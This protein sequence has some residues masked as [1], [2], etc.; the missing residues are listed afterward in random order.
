MERYNHLIPTPSLI[1]HAMTKSVELRL[2]QTQDRLKAR[3][4]TQIL[5]LKKEEERKKKLANLSREVAR[6]V[7]VNEMKRQNS[8]PGYVSLDVC[9]FILYYTNY[10]YYYYH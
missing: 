2:K 5:E 9:D 6:E 8:K 1:E 4:K 10:Y 3:K 7:R